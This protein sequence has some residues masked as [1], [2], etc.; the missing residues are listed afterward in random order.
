MKRMKYKGLTFVYGCKYLPP[1]G[2]T[3]ITL[4]RYVFTRMSEEDLLSY[5]PTERGRQLVNHEAM[6]IRQAETFKHLK[7]LRFYMVYLW[8]FFKAWPFRMSWKQAYRTICFELEAYD[9]QSYDNQASDW[10]SYVLSIK[11]RKNYKK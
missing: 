1:K 11:E 6:H 3:A 7:W 4:F 2:Y 9:W 8:Q 10:R 5:L